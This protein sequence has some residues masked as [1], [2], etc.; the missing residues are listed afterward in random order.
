[1]AGAARPV[2]DASRPATTRNWPKAGP[3]CA[4]LDVEREL[5]G[6]DLFGAPTPVLSVLH[7]TPPPRDQVRSG[8]P[9]WCGAAAYPPWRSWI[10]GDPTV[11]PY[12]A[13]APRRRPSRKA[14]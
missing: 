6:S 2:N 7:G 8:P 5:N 11:I 10:D 1:M 9:D 14:A 4:P 13:H 3:P 12:R